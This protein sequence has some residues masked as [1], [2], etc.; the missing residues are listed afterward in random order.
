[1]RKKVFTTVV[2]HNVSHAVTAVVERNDDGSVRLEGVQP[3]AGKMPEAD[4]LLGQRFPDL[5][6]L[7]RALVAAMRGVVGDTLDHVLLSKWAYDAWMDRV[8]RAAETL[9]GVEPESIPDEM[10]KPLPDGGLL[11]W[12]DLPAGRVDLVVPIGHWAW[13]RQM[14]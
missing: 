14:M 4:H 5:A 7:R 3:L 13:R 9:V 2:R 12:V 6:A 1:M 10:A 8:S 11:I